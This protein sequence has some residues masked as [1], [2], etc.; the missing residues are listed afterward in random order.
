[1][2]DVQFL[3]NKERTQEEFFHLFNN[4]YDN[5]K[6]IIFSSDKHPHFIPGLQERL[7]SRLIAG[8]IVDIPPPDQESRVAILRTKT[9]MNNFVLS[10]EILDYLA[11]TTP[12]NIRELEGVLN[13]VICQSQLKEKELTLNEIKNLIKNSTKPKKTISAKEVVKII[14]DFY[15]IE[16]GNIYDKIRKKEIIKPRQIIM[17]ILREDFNISYPSI[18]EKLGGRDHTTVIHSCEKIKNDLKIDNSLVQELN[19][20]RAMIT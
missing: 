20:I 9:K 13:T 11:S 4:L 12:N 1:M 6:Q 10:G 5:N 17:Y 14:A 8:M 2:D 19:Q 16:E 18:G 7:K 3:S 15:N